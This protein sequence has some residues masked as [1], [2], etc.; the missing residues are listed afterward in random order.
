MFEIL[1]EASCRLGLTTGFAEVRRL[2][3]GKGIMVNGQYAKAWDQIVRPGDIIQVG[4]RK[5]AIV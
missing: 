2:V 4:K 5:T 1:A 3:D